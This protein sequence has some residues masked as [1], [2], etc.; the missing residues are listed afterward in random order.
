M[1]G[2]LP[3]I[4]APDL[5]VLFCG[6]NPGLSAAAEGH[7]FVGRSNRFWRT[8]HLAGLTPRQLDPS[9]DWRLLDHGCGLTTLVAR[10]SAGADVLSPA[11]YRGGAANLR[12][13]VER[14]RPS[15]VAFLGKAGWASL[16][17]RRQVDWGPQPDGFGAS[18]VWVLP[19]P[20][21]RNRA[22][23]LEGLVEA[24]RALRVAAFAPGG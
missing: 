24:Y 19:N 1:T 12:D 5:A 20:S 22:F 4:L 16:S 13:K 7:H 9:E 2:A 21:G 18:G 8:L 3:D 14:A 17:G 15:F 10:A 11:E 6:L 23:T